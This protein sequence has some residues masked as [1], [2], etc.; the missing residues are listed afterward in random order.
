VSRS[1][2][3]ILSGLFL[4]GL[5]AGLFTASLSSQAAQRPLPSKPDPTLKDGA[6]EEL[7]PWRQ[8][9]NPRVELS[10]VSR[11][12]HA[13]NTTREEKLQELTKMVDDPGE[14]D[15]TRGLASVAAGVLLLEA[16]RW[17]DADA[18]LTSSAVSATAIDSYALYILG[19]EFMESSPARAREVLERLDRAARDVSPFALVDEARMRLGRLLVKEGRKEKA[20]REF[21]KI[22][23]EG[24]GES[25]GAALAELSGVL[26]DLGKKEEAVQWLE[27][28]YYELPKHRL[29]SDAGR[30]LRKLKAHRPSRTVDELYRLSFARAEL[31]F[32]EGRYKNAYS[33]YTAL[34]KSYPKQIDREY[35]DLRRGICQYRRRQSRS[36]EATLGRVKRDEFLAE[37]ILYR[38]EAA[39]RLRKRKTY[40]KRLDAVLALDPKGPWAEE[41]LWSLAR[42]NVVEDDMVQ[43]LQYYERLAREFPEGKHYVDAQWRVLWDQYRQGQYAEAARGFELTARE[44][45]E[46]AELS[47]FLYWGARAYES[48]GRPDRAETLYRQLLLGY[49]NTYYGRQ[50]AEHLAR[51]RGKSVADLAAE[52]GREGLDLAAGFRVIRADRLETIGQLVAV[53]LFDEAEIET[54]R[55][56]KGHDDDAAFRAVLAWLYYAQ[57]DFR[58]AIVTIREAFPFHASATGDL[59]PKSVWRMLYPVKYFE[60]VERYAK[61][62]DVDPFVVAGLIRQEST[63]NPRARSRVGARGLMQIM[64][65][66]GRKLARAH[67]RRY[68][69]QD[70]YNPEINIRYGT[71]YLKEVLDRFGGRLDYA[72]AS[73]NAGPHRVK[74]WTGMDATLDAEE[75]IEEIPFTETRNYVKLVLRNEMLYRRLYGGTSVTAVD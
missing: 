31:L 21:R 20:A 27:E 70:L 69:T 15:V 56:I 43:A 22:L 58:N 47:R 4:V 63:F 28:L 65:Y 64:P 55:A 37:A 45:P 25:R 44:H 17:A 32:E 35:V 5:C 75:F 16:K 7:L 39:R 6:T 49:K 9:E 19:R 8:L 23:E 68:R 3:L 48:S 51:L 72:L 42:Y 66:T 36:A 52:N 59:L 41:A 74:A 24:R 53:G 14:V 11:I 1:L 73:Y 13:E 26:I 71:H 38:G 57:D 46:A 30:K 60:F 61:D 12:V 67:R 10:R 54:K 18:R 33:D 40:K 2:Y 62:H 29:S 34:L 50:A